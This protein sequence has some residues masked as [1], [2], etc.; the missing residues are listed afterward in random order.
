MILVYLPD[1]GLFKF[2]KEYYSKLSTYEA[3][4]TMSFGDH[5]IATCEPNNVLTN[6]DENKLG[7]VPCDVKWSNSH[8]ID[9]SA[10]TS[11]I[12][13]SAASEG[14]DISYG[15]DATGGVGGV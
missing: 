3:N 1:K 15:S 11:C 10:N 5:Y 6:L 4:V 7:E 14:I 2:D 12:H 9:P 13:F 8:R